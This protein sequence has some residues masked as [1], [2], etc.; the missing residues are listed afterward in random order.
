MD[1]NRLVQSRGKIETIVPPASERATCV[2]T[3]AASSPES[4]GRLDE[5]PFAVDFDEQ[6]KRFV[7][8]VEVRQIDQHHSELRIIWR[9]RPE[10]A[11]LTISV[12]PL[13]SEPAS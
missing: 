7:R 13:C 9:H 2:Q 12:K 8:G 1:E 10:S 4:V 11:H 6:M 3:Q 5:Q